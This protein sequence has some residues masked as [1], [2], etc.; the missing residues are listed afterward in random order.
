MIAF[1][2]RRLI[3]AAIVMLTVGL[4]AF[5]LFRYVGDPVQMMVS[6]E[7]STATRERLRESLGLNDPAAVQFGRFVWNAAHGDFGT[8]YRNRRPV[9]ELIAGRLPATLEL[10][11]CSGL[12]ALLLGIPMG[13]CS[14]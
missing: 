12:F 3:Q 2:C 10:V 5:S 8:S 14:R 6:E 1:I 9:S 13:A 4:V 11:L 7:D